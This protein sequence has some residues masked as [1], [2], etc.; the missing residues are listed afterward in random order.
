MTVDEI[1]QAA[2]DGEHFT[3]DGYG[4]VAWYLHEIESE[5]DEDT[6]WTGLE[7]P[8]G[9]VVL[10]MVGDDRSHSVDPDDVS[11][12]G[13]DDYCHECGQVGCRGDGR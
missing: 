9:R 11:V 12:I 1:T 13:E 3:V 6:E 2:F 5:P 8:T 4:G 10:V 7:V